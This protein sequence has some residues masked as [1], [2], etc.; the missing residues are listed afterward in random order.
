[1]DDLRR[2]RL[3][4]IDDAADISPVDILEL[5]ADD[6]RRG[7]VDADAVLIIAVKR[8]EDGS[9]E[10][11]RYRARMNRMEEYGYLGAAQKFTMDKWLREK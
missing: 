10:F 9:V 1:M 4:R 3:D 2:A 5:A 6:I 8:C 7:K 11:E